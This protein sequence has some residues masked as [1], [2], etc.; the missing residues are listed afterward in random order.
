MPKKIR[1]WIMWCGIAA[2]LAILIWLVALAMNLFDGAAHSDK[3][4]AVAAILGGALGASGAALA[5]YLTLEA[6]RG[7]E[8]EKVESTLRMETAEFGRLALGRLEVCEEILAKRAHI[9]MTD[10]QGIMSMPEAVVYKATADRISRLAYGELFVAFHARIAEATSM[11][12]MMAAKKTPDLFRGRSLPT[13]TVDSGSAKLFLIAWFDACEIARSILRPGPEAHQIAAAT[14]SECL[15]NLDA[16]HTR[17]GP[18]VK[19]EEYL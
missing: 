1:N 14:I 4:A 2:A 11:A 13:P 7:D 16:A 8:A 19:S 9:P 18:L 3:L 6:Q 5:V 15:T 17:V 12:T 10:L